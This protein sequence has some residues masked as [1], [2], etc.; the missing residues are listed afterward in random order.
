MFAEIVAGAYGNIDNILAVKLL[1]NFTKTAHSF[2]NNNFEVPSLI[3]TPVVTATELN[4][5]VVLSWGSN[6]NE[7]NRV[8]STKYGNSIFEG[9]NV[10]QIPSDTS[11]IAQGIRIATYDLKDKILSI[12]GNYVDPNSADILTYDEQYGTDSGIQRFISIKRDT[13]N[14]SASL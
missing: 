7:I 10:Y 1:K 2:Y 9:Y 13:I 5:E 14:E 11:S 8:E 4:K 12:V 6:L 3:P